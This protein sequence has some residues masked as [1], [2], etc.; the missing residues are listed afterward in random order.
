MRASERAVSGVSSRTTARPEPRQMRRERW[1]QLPQLWRRRHGAAAREPADNRRRALQ[2]RR[3]VSHAEISLRSRRPE[4]R[5]FDTVALCLEVQS[6]VVD[7]EESGRLTL[8]PLRGLK[9]HPDRLSL[10]LGG[11]PAGDLL[12]GG[13][14]P[15]SLLSVRSCDFPRGH[16][17][18][19]SRRGSAIPAIRD[20]VSAFPSRRG[21]AVTHGREEAAGSGKMLEI[22]RGY[23]GEQTRGK[24][25]AGRWE[26]PEL[27]RVAT[28]LLHLEVQGLVV[29][30]E[31]PRRLAPVPTGD[32]E[33]P[34]DRLLLGVRRGRL[35][36]VS[37]RGVDA[38]RLSAEWGRR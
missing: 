8:V 24:G 22:W 26:P 16:G 36:D 13:L 4:L 2:V 27:P 3:A 12:Q 9:G 34:A 15:F 10:R 38:P 21:R 1:V 29:G 32:L 20:P 7:S 11:G 18:V 33:D 25:E 14:H 28:V 5:G 37:Q 6:L 23:C 35:G 30:S 31:E 17:P 19:S